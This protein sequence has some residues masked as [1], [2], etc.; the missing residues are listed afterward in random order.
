M[1]QRKLTLSSCVATRDSCREDRIFQGEEGRS[2]IKYE[3]DILLLLVVG[4]SRATKHPI[5]YDTA[6]K[7]E[8]GEGDENSSSSHRKSEMRLLRRLLLSPQGYAPLAAPPL[9]FPLMVLDTDAGHARWALQRF[10]WRGHS[11]G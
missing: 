3:E 10:L 8:S 6:S 7:C 5:H 9:G 4:R 2:D 11:Y 1:P